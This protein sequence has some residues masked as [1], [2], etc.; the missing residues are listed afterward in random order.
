MSLSRKTASRAGPNRSRAVVASPHG[1]ERPRFDLVGVTTIPAMSDPP[2][3]ESSRSAAGVSFATETAIR[4]AIKVD[5]PADLDEI[6]VDEFSIPGTKE[7]VDLARV[8]RGLSCFEI[9]TGRDDLRRLPRQVDAF[10][11]LFDRCT[12]VVDEKHL[13]GCES[14]VPVW[15]G[16]SVASLAGSDVVVEELRGGGPNPTCDPALLV[17]LLWK[18]EVELA[19]REIAAPSP[20]EASRQVLWASL[21]KHGSPGEVKRLVCAALLRRD[22]RG[23]R[24]PS[25]RFG[26]RRPAVGP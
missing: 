19:V 26:V 22:G 4:E 18:G 16:I 23:A 8:G 1:Q 25:N 15:W 21:L 5:H 10:S 7:R 9:K 14:V 13:D 11:R 12:V 24:L 17:R 6:W 3:Q 20:A 2:A